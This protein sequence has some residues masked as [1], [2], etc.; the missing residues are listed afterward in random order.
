VSRLL[1]A[2]VQAAADGEAEAVRVH[3][4]ETAYRRTREI[5]LVVRTLTS[6]TP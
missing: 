2:R 3:I 6:P 5:E 4:L 1:P